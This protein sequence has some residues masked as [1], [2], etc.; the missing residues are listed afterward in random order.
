VTTGHILPL[1]AVFHDSFER[2]LGKCAFLVTSLVYFSMCYFVKFFHYKYF[3][4]LYLL[5]QIIL[6]GGNSM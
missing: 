6:S 2:I 5:F 1:G 4:H 3:P